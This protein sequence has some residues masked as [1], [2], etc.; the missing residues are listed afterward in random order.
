MRIPISFLVLLMGSAVLP[1]YAEE[2]IVDAGC[3]YVSTSAKPPLSEDIYPAD[4][5]R[6]DGVDTPNRALNRYRLPVGRH[7][8]AVQEQ[9]GSTPRGYTKLRKLGNKEVALVYKII[10]IDIEANTSY[11]IGAQL[12]PDKLDPQ[13]PNAY[14]SPVVWRTSTEEC[15]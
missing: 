4:I 8:I 2:A 5:T 10:K 1:A 3:G 7:A 15:G 11:Q 6:L 12:H 9:I 13:Q 14:W